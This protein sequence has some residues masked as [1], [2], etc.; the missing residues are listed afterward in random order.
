M[1]NK[2]IL[3][4]EDEGVLLEVLQKRLFQDGYSVFVARDGEEGITKTKE[5]RPDLILLDILMPKKDGFQVLEE[6]QQDKELAKI[7]VI[8]ISNS[9]QGIEIEKAQKMGVKDY[10]IK[11]EFDPQEVSKKVTQFFTDQ[12]N[13]KESPQA[14]SDGKILIV[15]DD[16]FLRDLIKT[17]LDQ[18]GYLTVEA[19]DGQVALKKITEEMPHLIFLDLVL[20]GEDGFSILQKVKENPATADIP[21]IILSNLGQQE[22][23]T[24]GLGLGAVDFLIKAHFTPTDIVKKI[25]AA[26][27]KK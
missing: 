17:K 18:A 9:G 19:G 7:P 2:K 13:Q 1:E 23:I 4:V 21:V 26:L 6:L 3:I 20:P 10:L 22:D 14:Q 11:T 15:E 8:I 27:S 16:K 24:K 5:V 12:S 25:K